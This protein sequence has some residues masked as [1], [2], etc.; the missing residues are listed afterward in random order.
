MHFPEQEFQNYRLM[1]NFLLK[2]QDFQG[3]YLF[4]FFCMNKYPMN[5]G[6]NI[7]R[8]RDKPKDY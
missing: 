3:F 8:V 5:D 6:K 1:L 2:E 4:L 7:E